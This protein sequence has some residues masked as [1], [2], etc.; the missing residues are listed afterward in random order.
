MT[1]KNI[2]RICGSEFIAVSELHKVCFSCAKS[3]QNLC[4][5]IKVMEILEENEKI[6]R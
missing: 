4:M 6:K 1:I 2:C 3:Q 5:M